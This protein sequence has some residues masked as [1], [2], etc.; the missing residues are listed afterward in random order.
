MTKKQ[1]RN[2]CTC[3]Q[4]IKTK[5]KKIKKNMEHKMYHM[6][7]DWGEVLESRNQNPY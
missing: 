6:R 7:L 2:T 5:R 1:R 4:Q 3:K